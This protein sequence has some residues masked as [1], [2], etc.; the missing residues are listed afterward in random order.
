MNTFND[1]I[2]NFQITVPSDWTFIRPE[3]SAVE[4]MKNS[5]NP[6]FDFFSYAKKTFCAAMKKHESQY[7]PYP[8][9]QVTCRRPMTVTNELLEQ[10][11]ENIIA[12]MGKSYSEYECVSKNHNFIISGNRAIF[13]KSKF[14]LFANNENGSTCFEVLSISLNIFTKNFTFTLG[15][16]G[17]AD[18]NYFNESE[19]V[20]IL[21][22][23]KC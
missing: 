1:E 14:K 6:N 4:Q 19:F 20:N 8:T 3:W 11:L 2:L 16:T 23:V 12:Q 15:L 13:I 9:L 7:H 17:S 21:K 22:S 18:T 5:K 10:H